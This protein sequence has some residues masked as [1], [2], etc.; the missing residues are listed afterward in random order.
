MEKFSRLLLPFDSNYYP[1]NQERLKAESDDLA[2][3]FNKAKNTLECLLRETLSQLNE[4]NKQ[5]SLTTELVQ[6]R[7]DTLKSIRS[8][9]NQLTD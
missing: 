5:G 4:S 7:G 8:P 3:F 1:T 9:I 6:K 2:S